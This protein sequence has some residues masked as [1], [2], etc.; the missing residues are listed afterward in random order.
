MLDAVRVL[1]SLDITWVE[2]AQMASLNPARL[3]NLS[4]ECG[5]I[6]IGKRADLIALNSDSTIG[7]TLVGGRVGFRS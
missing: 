6:E 5:S 4:H 2:I 1:R 7:L 3:L